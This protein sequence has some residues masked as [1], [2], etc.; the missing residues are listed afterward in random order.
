MTLAG[1]SARFTG[2]ETRREKTAF[3]A[4]SGTKGKDIVRLIAERHQEYIARHVEQFE[5]EEEANKRAGSLTWD[6]VKQRVVVR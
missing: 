4:V 5:K 2:G 1:G 6:D 3:D